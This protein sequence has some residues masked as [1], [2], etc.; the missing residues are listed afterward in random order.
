MV[1]Q[2]ETIG[3][4]AKLKDGRHADDR[5]HQHQVEDVEAVWVIRGERVVVD[6]AD[7]R[8]DHQNLL[9]HA[10]YGRAGRAS[11]VKRRPRR[12]EVE[13][14]VHELFIHCVQCRVYR[15]VTAKRELVARD[16]FDGLHGLRVGGWVTD[17]CRGD[18][19][20][21]RVAQRQRVRRHEQGA[22]HDRD[23][24][25]QHCARDRRSSPLPKGRHRP[26]SLTRSW[27]AGRDVG[28]RTSRH[29]L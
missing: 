6:D 16:A 10:R 19:V 5:R 3:V 17:Q 26:R 15:R 11:H 27:A 29:S 20:G 24:S 28:R 7:G 23:R 25:D 13:R 18:P 14:R 22:H 8:I 2:L 21:H 12:R 4:G 1:A 9:E